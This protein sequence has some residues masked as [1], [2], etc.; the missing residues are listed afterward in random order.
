[1]LRTLA[2]LCITLLLEGGGCAQCQA[3]HYRQGVTLEDSKAEIITNIS[4]S[5]QD[6]SPN[7]LVCLARSLK[8]RYQGRQSIIVSIFSSHEAAM[9]SIGLPPPEYTPRAVKML[10]QMH[11]RYSYDAKTHEDYVLLMPDPLISSPNAPINTKFD[12]SMPAIP[13]CKLQI[14]QRCLLAFD[15][16]AMVPQDEPGIVVVTGEIERN[17]SVSHVRIADASMNSL[18]QQRALSDFVIRN[19]ESWRFERGEHEDALRIAYSVEHV[20]TPLEHGMKAEFMLPDKVK[21]Q[22]GLFLV[23]P[24]PR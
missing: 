14:N 21:I 8:E 12:L 20:D 4:I 7:K 1:M 5:F 19:L 9:H 23:P 2:M 15:H 13:A 17:G 6:F 18:G 22:I 3:P 16:I 11:G 10:A 24:L